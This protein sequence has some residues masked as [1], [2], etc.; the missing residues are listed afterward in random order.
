M[1]PSKVEAHANLS[2]DPFCRYFVLVLLILF[3]IFQ[4]W[5]W[6]CLGKILQ[7]QIIKG[8]SLKF[9]NTNTVLYLQIHFIIKVNQHG[10]QDG[11][12]T[13]KFDSLCSDSVCVVCFC[14][15]VNWRWNKPRLRNNEKNEQILELWARQRLI[16]VWINYKLSLVSQQG[17]LFCQLNFCGDH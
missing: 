2:S 5:K 11:T 15:W 17:S 1:F 14:L 9:Q 16:Q 12:R 10:T 6:S 4:A 7:R 13:V 8:E 3:R